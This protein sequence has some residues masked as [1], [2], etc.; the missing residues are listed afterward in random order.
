MTTSKRINYSLSTSTSLLSSFPL[1]KI[2]IWISI[3]GVGWITMTWFQIWYSSTTSQQLL[4]QQQQYPQ[5]YP[6]QNHFSSCNPQQQKQIVYNNDNDDE[7]SLDTYFATIQEWPIP[8]K[9]K[10]LQSSNTIQNSKQ[11]NSNMTITTSNTTIN[12]TTTTSNN[13]VTIMALPKKNIT[14]YWCIIG[15]DSNSKNARRFFI[16]FPHAA[17][18]LLPCWSWWRRWRVVSSCGIILLDD[19]YLPRQSWQ[20]QLVHHIWKC[21]VHRFRLYRENGKQQIQLQLQQ[22]QHLRREL[23]PPNRTHPLGEQPYHIYYTP[24]LYWKNP[25][26]GYIRYLD[27]PQDAWALR[28]YVIS[29]SD[30]L[31]WKQGVLQIGILQR[32]HSRRILHLTELIQLLQKQIP[33]ANITILSSMPLSIYEQAHWF[34][35]KDIIIGSHGAAMMNCL[36][37]LS[38]TIV[39]QLYPPN[40]FFQSLEPLIELVGGI[41]LDWYE[42]TDPVYDWRRTVHQ[43]QN[44]HVRDVN[45]TISVSSLHEIV[46]PILFTMGRKSTPSGWENTAGVSGTNWSKV[47]NWMK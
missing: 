33:D 34:A 36:F 47:L 46:D 29:D 39:M 35:T 13:N 37:I 1:K 11:Q 3:L 4:I 28:R 26:Y 30:I 18:A 7:D 20:Y 25:R 10:S 12:T 6:Q 41:A 24:S 44:N 17:E 23:V 40:Y 9:P 31:Q 8:E 16:H 21:P 43:G 45:I 19:L 22:Q 38:K 15:R 2:W 42:G 5:Q 27:R 32:S 14:T